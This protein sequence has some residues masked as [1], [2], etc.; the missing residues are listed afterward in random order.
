LNARIDHP[1]GASSSV[2]AR[3]PEWA[4]CTADHL[5]NVDF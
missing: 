3:W 5:P 4:H 2:S 1:D